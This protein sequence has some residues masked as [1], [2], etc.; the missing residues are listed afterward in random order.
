[1]IIQHYDFEVRNGGRPVYRGDT[2]F[3]FFSKASLSQ[4]VGIRDARPHE[5]DQAERA[6]ARSFAFPTEAPLPDDRLRMIDCV[7]LLVP[8][9]GPNGLGLVHGSKEVRP[10][11]WFFKAHFYQDPVIP[12]SLGLE[13]F[14]QLLKVLA[15]ERWPKGPSDH[16]VTM[17]GRKHQWLYRGQVIPTNRRVLVQAVVTSRDDRS[18]QLTAD[19]LLLVDGRVIYKMK[20]FTLTLTTDRL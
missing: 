12:G 10:E 8:D 6:R 20:D 1:M 5:P 7:E 11:E 18:R 19:G 15:L 9:G 13:S 3:G 2:V 17:T 4:Q 16:Y 14:L